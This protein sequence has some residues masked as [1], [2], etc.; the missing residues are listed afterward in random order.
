MSFPWSSKFV[1]TPSSE[2]GTRPVTFGHNATLKF[3]TFNKPSCVGN[4]PDTSRPLML[5][6]AKSASEPS[7]DGRNPVTPGSLCIFIIT[8]FVISAI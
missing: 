1:Y 3:T 8:S 6:F 7:C 2:A 4:D 5:K